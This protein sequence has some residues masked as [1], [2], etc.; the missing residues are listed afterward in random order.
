MVWQWR[1]SDPGRSTMPRAYAVELS[2]SS[3]ELQAGLTL[4]PMDAA[5][6]GPGPWPWPWPCPIR[7]VP[8]SDTGTE[9]GHGHK[10]RPGQAS[11]GWG[12]RGRTPSAEQGELVPRD[13]ELFVDVG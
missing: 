2:T 9:D 4:S 8:D 11:M 6:P 10:R 13:G 7:R 3:D 12:A 1:W 5:P